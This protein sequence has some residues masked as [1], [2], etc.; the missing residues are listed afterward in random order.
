MSQRFAAVAAGTPATAEPVVDLASTAPELV[1]SLAELSA[2]LDAE[3][4]AGRTVGLVPTMGALH[5]GHAELIRR[6]ATECDFVVVSVF[7]NPLQFGPGED[8]ERY[9]RALEADQR[10]AGQAGASVVFAPSVPDMYPRPIR[11][12]VRVE[13]LAS[14]LEGAFRP[15]HLDGVSTVVAKLFAVTG[16]CRAYFGEKDWQQ[17]ILVRRM[18]EDLSFPIEVV[19]CPTVWPC[20]PATPTSRPRNAGWRRCS[21]W[22]SRRPQAWRATGRTTPS[23]SAP[24][25]SASW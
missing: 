5:R 6:A 20:H 3:R 9:P 17:L 15:G 7:V 4:A 23:Y 10:L 22:P 8:F 13:G 12:T 19:G 18:A 2:R 25:W 21:I 16:R 24:P 11:T 1:S 14:V